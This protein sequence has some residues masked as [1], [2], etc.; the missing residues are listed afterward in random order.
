MSIGN[1]IYRLRKNKGLTQSDI[2]DKLNVSFQSVS[3]WERDEAV[4]DID[5]LISLSELFNVSMDR[6]VKGDIDNSYELTSRL[7][8][9][10]KMYTFIKTY[11]REN[12]LRQTMYALP[13]AREK[14]TGQYRKGKDNVPYIYHP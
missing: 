14:H 1:N 7:F 4:P 3:L 10:D 5:N 13:L 11:A 9:E 6:L 8:D 2:A 12:N